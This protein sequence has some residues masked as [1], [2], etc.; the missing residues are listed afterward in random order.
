MFGVMGKEKSN[1]IYGEGNAYD[2]GARIYDPRIGRWLSVD[3]LQQKYPSFS[4]YNFTMNNPLFYYDIDG[5][6]VGVTITRNPQGGGS[7]TFYSTTYVTGV[8]AAE[9]VKLY[10][11]AFNKFIEANPGMKSSDGKWDVKVK[12]EFKVASEDD[13]KR[14]TNNKQEMAAENMMNIKTPSEGDSRAHSGM[15]VPGSSD[16]GS[17]V[18]VDPAGNNGKGLRLGTSTASGRFAQMYTKDGGRTGV[19]EELHNWGIGDYYADASYQWQMIDNKTGKVEQSG[20][21]GGSSTPYIGFEGTIMSA[22][23]GFCMPQVTVD[24]LV[25]TA[26]KTSEVKKS[27]NFVMARKVDTGRPNGSTNV[28]QV[29]KTRTEKTKTKTTT[30]KN[31]VYKSAGN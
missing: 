24:D 15:P 13:V 27:D 26:L 8:D 19:H 2:F 29:P 10:N 14:I 21:T 28:S 12:M 7:I 17:I 20:T 25:N 6:D 18:D 30:Y 16:K 3:P 4:P 9:K 11:E 22:G 23:G 5:K 1:E 31:P